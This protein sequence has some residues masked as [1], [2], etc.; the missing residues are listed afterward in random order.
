MSLNY[1][2]LLLL[3]LFSATCC[4][5]KNITDKIGKES[6]D[7]PI[8]NKCC[9]EN[10]LFVA[11]T[12]YHRLHCFN[13]T[14]INILNYPDIYNNNNT[15]KLD[16]KIDDSFNISYGVPCDSKILHARNFTTVRVDETIHL[17]ENGT[18]WDSKL[19]N[20]YDDYCI[21][22]IKK[23]KDIYSII[24]VCQEQLKDETEEYLNTENE[25]II[26]LIK[27]ILMPSIFLSINI[28]II[29]NY[30]PSEESI[31]KKF[32]FN[33]FTSFSLAHT[34]LILSIYLNNYQ[35]Q[36]GYFSYYFFIT[37]WIWFLILC[38]DIRWTLGN[39][40]Y[41]MLQ[42]AR[43]KEY[44]IYSIYGWGC[45]ILLTI[46][47]L[48]INYYSTVEMNEALKPNIGSEYCG[49]M[50]KNAMK[51]YFFVP[52]CFII[53]MSSLIFISIG[54]KK[55]KLR[56]IAQYCIEKTQFKRHK[57]NNDWIKLTTIL[58]IIN[59]INWISQYLW[60]Q[61]VIC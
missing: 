53:I 38:Y 14:K 47:C 23:K 11:N 31:R 39:L 13:E 42:D 21:E 2:L 27:N 26:K 36:T 17:L 51:I 52:I 41:E 5:S 16:K 9:E 55:K 19:S 33:Y 32:I 37:S 24:L 50:N 49:L 45:G 46:I 25:I 12:S 59:L 57:D 1:I 44:T 48:I 6:N 4:E 29:Y 10:Q 54:L 40:K 20:Y 56:R 8:I 3:I 61:L 22:N 18:I 34:S 28:I 60:T 15:D 7:K 30:W 35:T 43:F 58:F